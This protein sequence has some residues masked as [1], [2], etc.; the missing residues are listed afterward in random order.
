MRT[1]KE[2]ITM[3]VTPTKLFEIIG[4]LQVE[5]MELTS[6]N[7][8]LKAY[9]NQMKAEAPSVAPEEPKPTPKRRSV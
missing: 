9:I 1:P 8:R 3:E 7:A 6:E 5:C 4:S 2:R